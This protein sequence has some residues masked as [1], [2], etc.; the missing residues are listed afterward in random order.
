M[1]ITIGPL[2]AF[3]LSGSIILLAIAILVYP[4]L[5]YGTKRKSSRK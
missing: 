3:Y 4:T 5:R 1:N 2:E